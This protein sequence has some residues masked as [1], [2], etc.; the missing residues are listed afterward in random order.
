MTFSYKCLQAIIALAFFTSFWW[1]FNLILKFV[2]TLPT[3]YL[4]CKMHS[5]KYTT[6]LLAQLTLRIFLYVFLVCC[7]LRILRAASHSFFRHEE[8]LPRFCFGFCLTLFFSISLL[9]VNS[10]RFL[11]RLNDVIGW[12]L[13]VSFKDWFIASKFQCFRI[14]LLM[15]WQKRL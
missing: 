7:L 13:N 5:I 9:P 15:F 14:T 4:F 1:L 12:Q 8:H 3:Y 2:S 11:F 6:Q 10:L